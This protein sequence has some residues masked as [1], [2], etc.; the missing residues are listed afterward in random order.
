MNAH[1][2]RA[3]ML[4]DQ[5]RY[6]L[7]IDELRQVLASEP[8]HAVAHAVLAICFSNTKNDNEAQRE[9][10]LA[11][12]LAPDQAFAFYAQALVM[13]NRN[14]FAAAQTAIETAIGLDPYNPNFFAQ[15]AQIRFNQSDWKGT[16]EAAQTGLSLDAESAA[17]TNLRAMA[18]VKLGRKIEAQEAIGAALKRAPEDEYAHA[19]MGWTLLEQNQPEKA[20]EHFR[21]SL[22]LNP[23]MDWARAGI[24]EAMKSRYFLYRIMLNWFLWMQKLQQKAQWGVI[25]GAYIG[26]QL[27]SGFA[28]KHPEW[29]P[30]LQPLLILYIAFALMTWVA[31]PLFNL[32][33]RT[34]PFGRLA[35]SK[36]QIRT[37]NWVGVCVL[38]G[39]MLVVAYFATGAAALLGCA[40]ACVLLIPPLGGIYRCQQ[41]WPRATL[42]LV[43]IALGFM[44]AV[45]VSTLLVSHWLTHDI[46][47]PLQGIGL[48]YFTPLLYGSIGAQFLT[49]ALVSATPKRGTHT[50]KKVWVIGGTLLGIAA[51]ATCAFIALIVTIGIMDPT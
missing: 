23:E 11:I 19:N 44:A 47:R 30:L 27:L 3:L 35:L 28:A 37:S 51:V 39:I 7:A 4:L 48:L 42:S 21:E 15:L 5:A 32:V 1:L 34:S 31:S 26:F 22:R 40:L 9:A 49:N 25:I 29:S 17:C 2:Q 12:H 20:M 41:G 46:R 43:T 36:E 16:L 6:E 24:I 38:S 13:A 8:N 50:E 45:V 33:L 10:E 18:L 14:Q